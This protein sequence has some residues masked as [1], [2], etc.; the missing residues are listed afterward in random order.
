MSLLERIPFNFV[1]ENYFVLEYYK[2]HYDFRFKKRQRYLELYDGSVSEYLD[3][4]LNDATKREYKIA[5]KVRDN[6]DRI[7]N[8]YE[9][10]Y[11]ENDV[12]LE[13]YKAVASERI[14]TSQSCRYMPYYLVDKN[15]TETPVL[16]GEDSDCLISTGKCSS[17]ANRLS[18]CNYSIAHER[19]CNFLSRLATSWPSIKKLYSLFQKSFSGNDDDI[20]LALRKFIDEF[21]KYKSEY[22]NIPYLI[23]TEKGSNPLRAKSFERMYKYQVNVRPYN[24]G[25]LSVA[26]KCSEQNVR[27]YIVE[28]FQLCRD[29]VALLRKLGGSYVL[30]I[31][32]FTQLD[33]LITEKN[34]LI[35]S[36]NPSLF[37][38]YKRLDEYS[39]K[40]LCD[41]IQIK[42]VVVP[43][44]ND[45]IL[46]KSTESIKVVRSN[47]MKALELFEKNPLPFDL[48]FD[49]ELI[50]GKSNL[51]EVSR[52]MI[53]EIVCHSK[54]FEFAND[55]KKKQLK[56]AYLS[57]NDVRFARI[58]W[59]NEEHCM[60]KQ[61][62]LLE[63]QKRAK[64]L[65]DEI[66]CDV[67]D[68][69]LKKTEYMESIGKIGIW[70][71]IDYS[72]PLE[73]T[74]KGI[75]KAI[76]KYVT[77][78]NRPFTYEE[79]RCELKNFGFDLY[80]E[81][82]IREYVKTYASLKDGFF[83]PKI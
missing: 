20:L 21:I 66:N 27:T 38:V 71:L 25:D 81:R 67:N 70:K 75:L 55:G 57:T 31:D 22:D 30:L 14:Y 53:R 76:R 5:V 23:G 28:Y 60:S 78:I 41:L 19:G 32:F 56:Y 3:E 52:S 40:F 15:C 4:F 7:C 10:L 61:D 46:F 69:P 1:Y 26:M 42:E 37:D 12:P 29:I 39:K 24:V 73:T 58:L 35:I 74:S 77:Q 17:L 48:D 82:T 63:Y 16:K 2:E 36:E 59:D 65:G 54:M 43:C 50:L 13:F 8:L 47:V 80:S 49:L 18:E 83:I 79:M 33:R 11:Q 64:F 72:M 44:C 62:I 68:I 34:V 9:I 51:N 45:V 6:A